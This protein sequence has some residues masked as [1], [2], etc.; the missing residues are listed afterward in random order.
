MKVTKEFHIEW[1]GIPHNSVPTSIGSFLLL[2][3]GKFGQFLTPPPKK[4]QRL[5]NGWFKVSSGFF[6]KFDDFHTFVVHL[7]KWSIGNKTQFS[8]TETQWSY[9]W[10]GILI[11]SHLTFQTEKNIQ[12]HWI[13]QKT[14]GDQYC[15]RQKLQIQFLWSSQ[16]SWT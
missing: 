1:A 5:K 13:F 12:W 4:C 6:T 15:V 2:F 7:V 14:S 10:N 3:I 8:I 11:F 9:N 16:K